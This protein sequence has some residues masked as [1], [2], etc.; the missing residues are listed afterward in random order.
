[1]REIVFDD[2]TSPG[3]RVRTDTPEDESLDACVKVPM[4]IMLG[5]D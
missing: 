2:L 1:M 3:F 5:E 4:T